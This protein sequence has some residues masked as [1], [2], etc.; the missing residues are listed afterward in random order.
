LAVLIAYDAYSLYAWIV[1]VGGRYVWFWA[2]AQ[3][4]VVI[5]ACTALVLFL[6]FRGR[7]GAA[8]ALVRRTLWIVS[9]AQLVWLALP[10]LVRMALRA[11]A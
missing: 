2:P 4:L 3:G 11:F 5:A 7:P 6:R 9:C 10:V 8:P 1:H